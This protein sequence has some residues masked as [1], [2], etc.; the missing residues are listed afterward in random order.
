MTS[1]ENLNAGETAQRLGVSYR[2][3][4]RWLEDRETRNRLLPG[5]RRE[6]SAWAIPLASVERLVT[7]KIGNLT[8]ARIT[9][10]ATRCLVTWLQKEHEAVVD[11]LMMRAAR[12]GLGHPKTWDADV[13][14]LRAVLKRVDDLHGVSSFAVRLGG[15]AYQLALKAETVDA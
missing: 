2:T 6:E 8:D 3:V 14:A 13:D 7:A 15:R 12:V 11:E 1:G 4:T 9:Q 5:A 10:A